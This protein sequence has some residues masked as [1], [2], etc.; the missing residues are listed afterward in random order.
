MC[1]EDAESHNQI[2]ELDCTRKLHP[3]IKKQLRVFVGLNNKDVNDIVGGTTDSG[4]KHEFG[5]KK[6]YK[7][8]GWL[9]RVIPETYQTN[10][11]IMI[12]SLQNN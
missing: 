2:P 9:G 12:L 7:R 1:V 4:T 8:K 10:L 3:N 5:V 11:Q 6:V